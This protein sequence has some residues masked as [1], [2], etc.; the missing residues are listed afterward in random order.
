VRMV[1][2]NQHG[3]SLIEMLVSLA[4]L[5]LIS[6]Y[7]L[8]AL[9][10]SRAYNRVGRQIE[11]NMNE[12]VAFER[13]REVFSQFQIEAQTMDEALVFEGRPNRF[14]FLALSNG[15]TIS[16]GLFQVEML[17]GSKD[18]FSFYWQTWPSGQTAQT[19]EEIVV[20]SNVEEVEFGYSTGEKPNAFVA[21]WDQKVSVPKK[22]KIK[23]KW[24]NPHRSSAVVSI[25]RVFPLG[26]NY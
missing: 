15:K 11:H 23:L 25:E 19:A 26:A 12:Q 21:N 18:D 9:N 17:K 16:G 13:L 5:S 7:G 1:D 14:R 2:T 20:F 4:L 22:I 3:F 10:Y 8:I 24:R 6:V